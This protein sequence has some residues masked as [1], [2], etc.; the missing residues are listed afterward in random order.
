MFLQV[1]KTRN[2]FCLYALYFILIIYLKGIQVSTDYLV[3][4]YSSLM[5]LLLTVWAIGLWFT[6]KKKKQE[7]S[8]YAQFRNATLQLLENNWS[9]K[10]GVV[11]DC[12]QNWTPLVFPH[13][14]F[15]W[16]SV[17]NFMN[18]RGKLYNVSFICNFSRIFNEIMVV[19][20]GLILYYWFMKY[21]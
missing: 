19:T 9:V 20:P 17:S 11:A 15:V 2:M 7:N 12:I 14:N 5:P 3:H 18:W 13:F 21:F 8:L 4:F 16:R 6:L 10:S 1:L